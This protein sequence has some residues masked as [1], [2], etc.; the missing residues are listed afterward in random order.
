MSVRRSRRGSWILVF[1]AAVACTG[2]SPSSVTQMAPT[3]KTP[4]ARPTALARIPEA[5]SGALCSAGAVFP[6]PGAPL[7][8][9]SVLAPGNDHLTL[10]DG[11][12]TLAS[13]CDPAR[14]EID[15]ERDQ[16]V[17]RA[18]FRACGA[19]TASATI[20]FEAIAT[21]DCTALEDVRFRVEAPLRLVR[22]PHLYCAVCGGPP[23]L[24][25]FA[26]VTNGSDG[27]LSIYAVEREHRTAS[28][29]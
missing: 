28:A 1:V 17:L 7:V 13:G 11:R 4:R 22:F 18:T 25:H 8:A 24:P 6:L 20:H 3:P 5:R 12:A 23:T 21:G 19:P 29:A 26:Y 9:G 15:H 27:T 10:L 14:L 16:S 2:E